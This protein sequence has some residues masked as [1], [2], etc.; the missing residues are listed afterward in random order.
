MSAAPGPAGGRG[1]GRPLAE[2]RGAPGLP[3]LGRV[4]ARPRGHRSAAP[5]PGGRSPRQ[6]EKL[7]LPGKVGGGG[8]A[9]SQARV[10]TNG[11]KGGVLPRSAPAAEGLM[12]RSAETRARSRDGGVRQPP[13]LPPW[14]QIKTSRFS[15][16]RP[17][18][19]EWG[20]WRQYRAW[21]AGLA[22]SCPPK[23]AGEE[24]CS[25]APALSAA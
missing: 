23:G 13:S 15:G 6:Q 20:R 12:S 24:R 5:A 21:G 22:Q 16:I 14:T 25:Q 3:R 9:S 11:W 1:R 17:P 4:T 7:P 10:G 18:Q 8:G 2:P 19:E